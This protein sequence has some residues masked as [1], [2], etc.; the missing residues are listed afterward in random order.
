MF[1]FSIPF[2]DYFIINLNDVC[3]IVLDADTLSLKLTHMIPV[4]F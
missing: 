3:F 2:S 1:D 4:N